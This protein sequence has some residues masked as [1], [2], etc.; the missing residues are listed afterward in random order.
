L[1]LLGTTDKIHEAI[2]RYLAVPDA[3]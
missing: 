2:E 3:R 1:V